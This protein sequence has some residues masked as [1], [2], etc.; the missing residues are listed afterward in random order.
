[1]ALHVSTKTIGAHRRRIFQK[2]GINSVAELTIWAIRTGLI[3][4]EP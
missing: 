4:I 2:L 1:A 3:T